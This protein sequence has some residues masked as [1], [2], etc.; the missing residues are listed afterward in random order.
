MAEVKELLNWVW[1]VAPEGARFLTDSRWIRPGD[2]LLSV[3]DNREDTDRQ[4][5]EALDKGASLI[6]SVVDSAVPNDCVPTKNIRDWRDQVGLLLGLLRGSLWAQKSLERETVLRELTQKYPE[7]AISAHL[8]KLQPGWVYFAK[9]DVKGQVPL[10]DI[11]KAISL[12]ASAVLVQDNGRPSIPKRDVNGQSFHNEYLI[13]GNLGEAVPFEEFSFAVPVRRF[14]L[15]GIIEPEKTFLSLQEPSFSVESLAEEVRA[16]VPSHAQIRLNSRHVNPGDVFMAIVGTKSDGRKFIPAAIANGASLVLMED[17]GAPDEITE[18][19]KVI[20]VKNLR[21]HAGKIASIFYG[22]PSEKLFGIAVTGTNGKTTTTQWISRILSECRY[23]CAVIGTLGSFFQGGSLEGESLTTP[24]AVTLQAQLHA[25]VEMGATAFAIEASSI[26]L[27]QGRLNGTR[28]PIGVYTNLT[29]DHLD[30]HGTM[31]AYYQAKAKLTDLDGFEWFCINVGND[32]G[33]RLLQERTS[34]LLPITYDR[35]ANPEAMLWAEDVSTQRDGLKFTLCYRP[36]EA[37]AQKIAIQTK[38]FGLFNVENLLAATS[39][40]LA[41]GLTLQE[42]AGVL[43]TLKAP[44]GRLQAVEYDKGPLV[45]VDYSHTPDSLSVAMETLNDVARARRGKLWVIAGCGGDR[46]PG[47]RPLMGAIAA[48]ADHAILTTDNPRTE[49]PGKILEQMAVNAK[50]AVVI[51][52]RAEAIQA[53]VNQAGEDDVILIAGKGHEDYQEIQGIKHHFSDFEEG[54]KALKIRYEGLDDMPKAKA[55]LREFAAFAGGSTEIVG[56]PE[57]MFSSLTFDSRQVTKGSLFFCIRAARDGHAFIGAAKENGAV[58]AVVDHF[59]EGIKIPQ[60][61]VDDTRRALLHSAASWRKWFK[62]PVVTVA[63]S[64]G[65]TT[66][67]QLLRSILLAKYRANEVVVTEG[68]LN[69]DLGVPLMLWK[70]DPDSLVGVFEAGMNHV[71]EMKP[72]VEAIAPTVS[73]LTNTQRDHVEFLGSLEQTARENGTV[74]TG[75]SRNGIAVINKEDQFCPLWKEMAG[76]HRIVTFGQSEADF[77]FHSTGNKNFLHTPEGELEVKF[78]LY[79]SHNLLNGAAA[80]AAAYSLGVSG[81]Q[82]KEGLESFTPAAHRSV[83][84]EFKDHVTIIDDS[85]NANPDSMRAAIEMLVSMPGKTK[86]FVMGDMKELGSDSLGFHEEIGTFAREKG[87]D[88]FVAYG[89]LATVAARTFGPGAESY[90]TLS[91]IQKRLELL[92]TEK[93]EPTILFKAS[94][95]MRLFT[96]AEALVNQ[97]KSVEGK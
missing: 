92:I 59:V 57:T 88:L 10:V 6:L 32:S 71:G 58:A 48:R 19:L 81:E 24:D 63:G 54:L 31:E 12:G 77:F 61:I 33:R 64:N 5:R 50:G 27:D 74:F 20:R 75:L 28:I 51:E 73:I 82:I 60:I 4:V 49:E 80:A 69:N 26:G 15:A 2:V 84:N 18:A 41:F 43:K 8:D 97:M 70:L 9:A 67:T 35:N 79:G 72:L 91:D 36:D 39:A 45:I 42:I 87:V 40:C 94:N 55:T 65:K 62:I 83:V 3:A 30:Y 38:L 53:A 52:D 90:A 44:K 13:T 23:P 47:K 78:P 66:T 14:P 68:N 56:D 85:Y 46:D 76:N 22:E 21:E 34:N 7:C 86:V 29:R 25:L 1:S 17:D 16:A 96:V 89:D 11:Q 37:P 93:Q 95:S